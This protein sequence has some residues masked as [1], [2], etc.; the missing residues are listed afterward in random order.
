MLRRSAIGRDR[1]AVIGHDRS[2]I[3]ATG[4]R[5]LRSARFNVNPMVIGS[6]RSRTS[7]AD[8]ACPISSRGG[9]PEERAW[10]SPVVL[11]PRACLWQRLLR[12]IHATSCERSGAVY[13]AGGIFGR[14]DNEWAALCADLEVR[15]AVCGW[16]MADCLAV[17]VAAVSVG[18]PADAG[19][20][21]TSDNAV[22]APPRLQASSRWSRSRMSRSATVSALPMDGYV[23]AALRQVYGGSPPGISLTS[24]GWETVDTR[25]RAPSRNDP[26]IIETEGAW[27]AVAAVVDR[28]PAG[29]G[30]AFGGTAEELA[31]CER[32]AAGRTRPWYE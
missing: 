13:P 23:G 26:R 12:S 9:M 8:R 19:A 7:Q 3:A 10:L 20:A 28:L 5:Q 14:L 32:V 27:A 21:D 29:C 2:A 1:F 6:D 17:E 24:A 31:P 15:G 18:R 30:P 25:L 11:G 22:I 4:G 16:L